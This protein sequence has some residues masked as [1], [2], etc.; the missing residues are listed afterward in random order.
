M[1]KT[2]TPKVVKTTVAR[3]G[4]PTVTAKAVTVTPKKAVRQ[5]YHQN[6]VYVVK[7]ANGKPT[8]TTYEKF[9]KTDPKMRQRM[10][11]KDWEKLS[12]GK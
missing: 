6:E 5:T 7:G 3:K 12:K 11:S 9:Q 10:S 1:K 8:T 2:T 4:N